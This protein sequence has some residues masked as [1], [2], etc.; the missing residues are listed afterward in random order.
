M[1]KFLALMLC[2][3][4]VLGLFAGCSAQS[5]SNK[6]G[7]PVSLRLVMYGDN[8]TRKDEF[9]KNEFHDKVLEELNIDFTIEWLPWSEMN[10]AVITNMLASGESFAFENIIS[11]NDFHTKGY[12]API[13]QE[14]IDANMPAYLQIREEGGS[15]FECAVWQDQIYCIPIGAKAYAGAHQSITVRTDL[16]EEAG[17][18]W[19]T[20]KTYEDLTA[21]IDAVKAIHPDITVMRGSVGLALTSTLA[22]GWARG[23]AI[24]KFVIVNELE[25]GDKVYSYYETDLFKN[26]TYM[27]QD[28]VAKGYRTEEEFT[29]ANKT[30]A[31]WTAGA[32]L[33]MY[34]VPG[35]LVETNVKAAFPEVDLKN[36]KIGDQPYVKTRDYDW[37]ISFSANEK[38]NIPHWL[39]LI[40]WIYESEAN[41]N[42]CIYGVEGKDYEVLEDGSIKKLVEDTFW[43]DWFLQASKYVKFDATIS[44]EN[45][46]AYMTNDVGSI[47]SKLSGFT[48]DKT[49]VETEAALLMAIY[50]EKLEPLQN[51]FGDYDKDFPGI[52][53]EMKAAGLDKYVAEYQ[54]QVSEWKAAQ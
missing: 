2:I 25:E 47:V 39:R 50:T 46:Q 19:K 31:D 18:D 17:V 49:P 14:D 51:G 13:S 3:I 36:I 11:L 45:I 53:E 35:N 38:E 7:K 29:N 20:I 30:E 27:M 37:A 15:G 34:G 41:Y 16:L 10:G 33:M 22:P 44:E 5:G 54:R 40:N 9:F 23:E 1:K 21:A 8:T 42:F 32:A 6:N 48:F 12:L 4:M 52:L 28:W 24:D 26:Y 43:D